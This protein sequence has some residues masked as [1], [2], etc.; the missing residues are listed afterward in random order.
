L[1]HQPV[2]FADGLDEYERTVT[3]TS[4]TKVARMMG[5]TSQGLRELITLNRLDA[6][7]QFIGM[8]R[9][10]LSSP[11]QRVNARIVNGTRGL[12]EMNRVVTKGEIQFSI[13]DDAFELSG[14]AKS[15]RELRRQIAEDVVRVGQLKRGPL[16]KKTNSR[17]RGEQVTDSIDDQ[18][19]QAPQAMIITPCVPRGPEPFRSC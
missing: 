9:K 1:G 11:S 2:N 12:D 3:H 18:G 4:I 7:W 5:Y 15:A 8:T 17:I 6:N 10:T 14:D 19:E 13:G 16:L